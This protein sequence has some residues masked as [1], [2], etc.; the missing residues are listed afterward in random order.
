VISGLKVKRER[1]FSVTKMPEFVGLSAFILIFGCSTPT[2]NVLA[3]A[4]AP[5]AIAV[6]FDI[7]TSVPSGGRVPLTVALTNTSTLAVNLEL[8]GKPEL[9]YV[10]LEVMSLSGEPVLVVPN[11][12]VHLR[13]AYVLSLAPNQRYAIPTHFLLPG[14]SQ[15]VLPPGEYL[16]R[17]QVLGLS[18]ILTKT[19]RLKIVEP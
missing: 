5:T 18:R 6:D 8:A 13:I 12:S 15:R 2:G 7:P 9:T 17:A 4:E 19:Q 3:K 16:V 10:S 14:A 1:V 11:A